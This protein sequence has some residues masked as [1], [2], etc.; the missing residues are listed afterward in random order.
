MTE[1][2][3]K[4]AFEPFFSTKERGSGIGLASAQ[5]FAQEM[6]GAAC[7]DSGLGEGT[8]V[9]LF[10]PASRSPTMPSLAMRSR[11]PHRTA[12][13]TRA[14]WLSKTSPMRSKR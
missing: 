6:G 9:Y 12:Q 1:D 5:D 11:R 2:V 8:A 3:L 13:P 14:Y 4:R 7:L 10:I